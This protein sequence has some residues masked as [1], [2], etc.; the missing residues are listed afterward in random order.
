MFRRLV[1][2]ALLLAGAAAPL[3]AQQAETPLRG[4]APQTAARQRTAEAAAIARPSPDSAAAHSRALSAEP[5]VAG[6]A[7]QART[8][9]YVVRKMREYGLETE[10]RAYQVWLPHATAARAW[11]VDAQGERELPL[12]EPA[13]AGDPASALPQ[14]PAALGYAR[15]GD[16]RA[17]VVFAGYGLPADFRRLDSLGVQ[18]RGRIVVA[19]F[20]R[21]F[22]GIKAREAEKAG[23]IGLILYSDPEDDGAPVGPV[24]P[25]GPMRPE[26]G[27]QR[28]SVYNGVGDPSTPGYPSVPGA[29]RARVTEW[30]GVP[31][32]PVIAMGS[33]PAAELLRALT[34]PEAPEDW[35]GAL[36]FRLRLGPGPVQAR[37]QVE[38]DA[39]SGG[40]FKTIWNTFGT[41][42]GSEFPDEVVMIGAHRD[43]WGPGAGDDVSGVA[44]VLEAAR[45]VAAAARAGERPKRTVVFA[46]WDAEEWGLIGSVEYV[47]QD[48]A[49]LWRGGVAYLNQDVAALGERFSAG[50]SPSLR[51]VLRDVAR[52][53]PDPSGGEG[54]VYAGWRR[55]AE[56]ADTLEPPIGDPGGGSDF[57]GFY[58]H[59]GIPHADWGWGGRQGIYHSQYDSHTWMSRFGDPGFRR[60]AASASLGAALLLRLANADILPYD[61]VEYGATMRRELP[62]LDSALAAKQW[63]EVTTAPLRG[64]LDRFDRAAGTFAAMRDRTLAAG[65]PGER[66]RERANLALRAVERGLTRARGLEG[67]PWYRTLVYA[68]DPDN[69]YATLVFPG[70]REAIRAGDRRRADTEVT[71]LAARFNRAAEALFTAAEALETGR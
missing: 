33:G 22:R 46:T 10:V 7:A 11:L 61:Y 47:E 65:R 52:L 56:V 18:V 49:R 37:V 3:P 26:R 50:G 23:A 29:R 30:T 38:T 67:R 6:T 13:V 40:A 35:Q 70:V 14:Y 66:A 42:R 8:R 27:I 60:H 55:S 68:S 12:A 41:L 1:P 53:V 59:L 69:G 25:E 57:A 34:G 51:A 58:N 44:S 45:A 24:Y 5:H 21:G 28:G 64:A 19:R 63:A 4:Y 15:A 39:G 2:L 32:I 16:V 62:A 54:S 17:E 9:D 36:G 71:D 43:A 48:S 20:G 31:R